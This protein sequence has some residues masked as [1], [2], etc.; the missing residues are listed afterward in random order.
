MQKISKAKINPIV[1]LKR[2]NELALLYRKR[3]QQKQ[4]KKLLTHRHVE[5]MVQGAIRQQRDLLGL[6]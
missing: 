4:I 3:R 6:K 1:M 5:I 2:I